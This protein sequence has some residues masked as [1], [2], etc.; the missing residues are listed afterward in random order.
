MPTDALMGASAGG[1]SSSIA[2][3]VLAWEQDGGMRLGMGKAVGDGTALRCSPG[4]G[5]TVQLPP[6]RRHL[7]ALRGCCSLC[8]VVSVADGRGGGGLG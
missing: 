2:A 1:G 4:A 7:P 3:A 8:I 6:L 5:C